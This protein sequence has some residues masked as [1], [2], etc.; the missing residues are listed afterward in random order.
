MKKTLREKNKELE[1]RLREAEKPPAAIE[2]GSMD[3]FGPD[4]RK[5]FALVFPDRAFRTLVEG[6]NQGAATLAR[7]GTV[8][9]CSR[10]LA[11]MV[12]RPAGRILGS[13][14]LDLVEE[15]EKG[16]FKSILR[17]RKGK[18][19]RGEFQFKRKGKPSLQVLV[20]C[21]SPG[22]E[23]PV[24]CMVVTDLTGQRRAE[25]RLRKRRER[26]EA[27][28][29]NRTKELKKNEEIL[30]LARN[31]LKTVIDNTPVGIAVT[32][33]KGG[34]IYANSEYE[35][36][37]GRDRPP[38][39]S[40]KDYK[41]YKAWWVDSGKPVRPTEWASARA[42]RTGRPVTGQT[43]KIERFGGAPAYVI[44]GAAP[45]FD[46]QGKIAG[47]V[48][49]I[50]D[51]TDRRGV[52][53]QLEDVA[54]KYAS[55]FNTTADG[56]WI[57]D[58]N[59][60]ILEVND[61]YCA[62]SGYT[63]E[64]LDHMPVSNLEAIETPREVAAHI[65]ELPRRGGHD[66]FESRH[67]RKD[68]S[69][70]DVDITALYLEREGGRIAMFVRDITRRKEMEARL[71]A[72]SREQQSLL[73]SSPAFIFYKD[74]E[75]RFVRVNKAMEE[76]MGLPRAEIE[77][78]PL[79]DIYPREQA[80][81]Y[82]SDDVEVMRSGRPKRGIIEEMQSARGPRIVETDKIPHFD[83]QGNLAGVI[84]FAIDITERR[85]AERELTWSARRHELISST[86]AR[87][88]RSTDP[89][90]LVEELCRDVMAFLDCDAFFN[91]LL[92]GETGRLR[93]NA[94]AGV[95]DPEAR[96]IEL[97]DLGDGVC[98]CAARDETRII[99]EDIQNVDDPRTALIRSYGIQAYCC[100]PLMIEGRLLGT[101]SFGTR[102]RERFT[103]NEVEVMEA[104]SN[105]VAIAMNRI[106]MVNALRESERKFSALF[107]A[108]PIAMSL[109]TFENGAMHD[110]NK[111]WLSMTGY[112]RK[113][114]VLGKTSVELGLAPDPNALEIV[115]KDARR[116]GFVRGAEMPLLTRWGARRT[117]LVDLH[118]V[119]IGERKF[120]L[121]ATVDITLRKQAEE[122]L[123][124]DRTTFERLVTKRTNELLEAQI[125]LE[126]TQR[127]ADIGALA[128]TIAHELRSPL[129][130]IGLAAHNVGKK[131]GAPDVAKHLE[132]IA[133]KVAE[134]NQIINNLLFYSRLK[135]PMCEPVPILD[136]LEETIESIKTRVKK[137]VSIVRDIDSLT[138]VSIDADPIQI[139]EVLGNIL[140]NAYDAVPP[141][142]GEVRIVCEAS[143]ETITIRVEDNGPGIPDE[144]VDKIFEPFFTTKVKGTG[145]GLSVCRQI[146]TMHDGEIGVTRGFDR[147]ASVFVRLRR[148][149][150]LLGG[151]RAGSDGE[152]D[153]PA[154]EEGPEP[155]S[156][157]S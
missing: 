72:Q 109:A 105:L 76:A 18:T 130:A 106:A 81:A 91:F 32:D 68:G 78:R 97:L 123:R 90:G 95:P 28:V 73:D 108:A 26:L 115:L 4:G 121:S 67:R 77:G 20:S 61:A 117:L 98:G 50:V 74:M 16:R 104:V 149:R 148:T 102:S 99:A 136:A 64:E 56:I 34:A 53:M 45:I 60:E 29:D 79:S 39:A 49:A 30:K 133:K 156:F 157:S 2:S 58:M 6:M 24:L 48:V 9:Y 116:K 1:S 132:T 83:E 145:L 96:K 113:E 71:Q 51:I 85:R 33:E 35:S 37:W 63:R 57:H 114:E 75:N 66:R 154:G 12:G 94:H 135:P 52:E 14:I 88:L 122:V 46:A 80:E 118:A 126:R 5:K 54:E 120:I 134:S 92:D 89:R 86:A 47:A 15:A 110:V 143:D 138:G 11:S 93:L 131:S 19:A 146:V 17:P 36:I 55:L 59:G 27:V 62:M 112:S 70:F 3:A 8:T 25:L 21:S 38:T 152:R 40:V 137:D 119:E 128:A 125:Q 141:A 103:R 127:L 144:I 139:R 142:G 107:R 100:H 129:A 87:L 140:N 44:N 84:G 82:W 13:P 7:D 42:I 124:R 153:Y 155:S 41:A 22:P 101:L 147:G 10:R 111:A 43:M 69:L 151:P 65:R 31:R 23:A 150:R